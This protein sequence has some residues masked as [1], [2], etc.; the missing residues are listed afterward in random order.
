MKPEK[1][2]SKKYMA[3]NVAV[4]ICEIVKRKSMARE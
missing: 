3:L 1:I 2:K 4:F